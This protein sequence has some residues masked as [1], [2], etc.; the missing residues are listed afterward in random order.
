MSVESAQSNMLQQ[1][2]R[3]RGV[4]D[5]RILHLLAQ[6]PRELFVPSAFQS[7]AYADM[8]I[9]LAHEQCMLTPYQEAKILDS[10]M[11]GAG[12]QVLE[13]GTGTGYLTALLAKQARQVVSI[14][15]F[16]TF[17]KQAQS[18]FEQL[19]IYNVSCVTGDASQGWDSPMP[20]D[21]IV[22]SGSLPELPKPFLESMS[23]GARL[24]AFIGETP[25]VQ[26]VLVTRV[27]A[28][29]WQHEVVFETDILPLL[30]PHAAQKFVF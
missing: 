2:I 27:S 28:K 19:G 10:V 11:V 20:L 30:Q 9:P 29:N 15:I 6:T 8:A 13:V 5:D 21:V 4:L 22:L 16:N 1:Q 12:E 18:K 25:V 17:A 23:L 7:E 26:A 14:D 24:F 3:A